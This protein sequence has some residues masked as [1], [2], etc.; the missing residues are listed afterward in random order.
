MDFFSLLKQTTRRIWERIRIGLS[1]WFLGTGNQ[2]L[3]PLKSTAWK[4]GTWDSHAMGL[5]RMKEDDWRESYYFLKGFNLPQSL[6]TFCL[7]LKL[8]MP[9]ETSGFLSLPSSSIAEKDGSPS[10]P[11]DTRNH[12]LS[13]LYIDK[14]KMSSKKSSVYSSWAGDKD[15]MWVVL[16]EGSTYQGWQ[17]DQFFPPLGPGLL[18]LYR[19][20]TDVE[21]LLCRSFCAK[22]SVDYKG[23]PFPAPKEVKS[24]TLLKIG[25][26]AWCTAL[27]SSQDHRT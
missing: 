24:Y 25:T 20:E 21:N 22:C 14:D 1:F 6:L 23:N 15:S 4:N 3:L 11:E 27:V 5:R 7:I 10:L 2:A 12:H 18:T 19:I 26:W 9:P 13:L 8:E 17:V 16:G